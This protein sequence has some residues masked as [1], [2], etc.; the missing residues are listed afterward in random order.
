MGVHFINAGW[1]YT[2][3]SGCTHILRWNF[4]SSP[5]DLGFSWSILQVVNY[6]LEVSITSSR[7]VHVSM[8]LLYS[9]QGSIKINLA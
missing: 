1:P 9:V 7:P 2:N 8:T 4:R 5:G 6:I 3:N